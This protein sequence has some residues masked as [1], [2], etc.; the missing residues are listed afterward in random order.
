VNVKLGRV[1]RELL[2]MLLR[3]AWRATAPAKLRALVPE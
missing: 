2:E 1:D 3:E